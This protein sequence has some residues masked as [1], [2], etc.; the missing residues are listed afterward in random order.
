MARND[1][2]RTPHA[3]TS[4]NDTPRNS[5]VQPVVWKGMR[6]FRHDLFKLGVATMKKNVSYKKYQPDLVPVEHAHFFHSVDMKGKPV[7]YS[8][9]I[10]GHFHKIDVVKDAQGNIVSVA[11]GPALRSVQKKLKS[12][13]VKTIIERVRF[14]NAEYGED[15]EEEG[16]DRVSYVYDEHVHEVAYVHSEMISPERTR[17]KQEA[18]AG[19]LK[20]MMT[21]DPSVV[22]G[23]QPKTGEGESASEDGTGVGDTGATISES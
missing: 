1:Q 7:E 10:G 15:D 20:S 11:C 12:G 23:S 14:A 21:A 5:P 3:Q 8:Q 4:Q 16:P 6:E 13:R 18:D 22:Q 9:P 19:K 2:S 17:L